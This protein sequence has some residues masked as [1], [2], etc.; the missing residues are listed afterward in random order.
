MIYVTRVRLKLIEIYIMILDQNK[1]EIFSLLV[2]VFTGFL[3]L[4][5]GYDKLFKIGIKECLRTF[6]NDSERLNVP[7]SLLWLVLGFTS[8]VEF[9]G[10]V[11]L[12]FGFLY[13]YTLVFLGIDLIIVA[14]A[15]GMVQPMWDTKH[16]F[17][18]FLLIVLNMFVLI[19]FNK[20][21][22]DKLFN[23]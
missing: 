23:L 19:Q 15:F 18:R 1:Y 8:F 17:P 16:A 20:Y 10:G 22:L 7:N 9:V 4:F 5:Q 3:F 11:F 12:I 6:K 21:T 13:T 2:R 14:V